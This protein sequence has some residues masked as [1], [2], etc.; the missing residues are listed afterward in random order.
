MNGKILVTCDSKYGATREIAEKIGTGLRQ[1]GLPADVLPVDGVRDLT[2]YAA[3]ILG[4]A[5]YVGNWHKA[6]EAILLANEKT[7]AAR[8]VWLFSGGPSSDGD[9]VELLQGWRLP[10]TPQPVAARIRPRDVAVFHGFINSDRPNIIERTSI[11]ALKKD[12][13]DFREWGAITAWTTTIA[14]ALQ[15]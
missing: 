10:A 9:P 4:S 15:A 8:P 12:F 7:F 6:A 14:G 13:G 3:V 11:K 2:A 1:A 5:V